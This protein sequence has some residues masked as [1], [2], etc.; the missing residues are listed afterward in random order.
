MDAQKTTGPAEWSIAH[1]PA[2]NTVATITRAAVAGQKHWVTSIT[3]SMVGDVAASS[4]VFVRLRDSTTGA[5]NIL[6]SCALRGTVTSGNQIM[7]T[8]LNI[9]GVSGQAVTLEFSGAGG[10]ATQQTVAMT[11]YTTSRF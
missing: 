7:L 9:E 8:G 3:A 2:A 6:W 4:I 10:A 11:G 1:E 5:G